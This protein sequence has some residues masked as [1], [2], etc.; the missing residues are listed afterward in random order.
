MQ[1]DRNVVLSATGALTNAAQVAAGGG[2]AA[3]A[4]S[5]SNTAT[6]VLL[7]QGDATLSTAGLLDNAGAIRAG[8]QLSLGV[9]S[10]RQTGQAYGLQRLGVSASGAVDNRGD[11]IGGNALRVEAGQLSSS[12]QLGSERGDVALISRGNLQLDGRLASA[13][14]FTAQADGAL[15]Q[16]GNLSAA[17]TLDL[18]STG[19]LTVAGQVAGQQLTLVSDA[20]VRQQGTVSGTTVDVQGARIENAGQTTAAGNLTLRAGQIGITGT[21]GAGINADGNLDRGSTLNLFADRQLTA[22]GT[23]LVGGNLTAQGSQ[24]QLAGATTRATGNVAL[25]T[26][27]SLDHRGGNL[28]A[29]G[30]LAVQAGGNI[31]NG[32]LNNVGGQLQA[33]Q[34]SIDGG[35]LSNVGGGLVLSGA[36]V[37]RVVIGGCARQQRRHARQ[38]RS[39]SEHHRCQY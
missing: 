32:R 15:T 10:L 14:A 22:S 17:S 1:A 13:G 28:L 8:N 34:L 19:D 23:L 3:T 29:G 4:A 35:S 7:A 27:G 16:S 6:G 33:N 31:D 30:T 25:T 12:G 39:G 24:L 5:A 11:L 36:G 9:G 18:R 37:T 2:L 26:G 21:V 38:Q 20:V